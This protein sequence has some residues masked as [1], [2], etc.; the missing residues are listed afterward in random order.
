MKLKHLGVLL[1]TCALLG[2]ERGAP[3]DRVEPAAAAEVKAAN[4]KTGDGKSADA[5]KEKADL[6]KEK[7]GLKKDEK[8]KEP[9]L[10]VTEHALTLGGKVIKYQSLRKFVH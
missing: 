6:G 5:G 3:R 2:Q 4:V 1:A 10:A 8:E 9:V 7:E